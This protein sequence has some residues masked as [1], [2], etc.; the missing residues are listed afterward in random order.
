MNDSDSLIR[1][2][3]RA[4]SGEM[5]AAL[6]YRGHWL[7]VRNERE[8][9]EIRQI[10]KE[11]WVHRERL[12][13][14]VSRL[15]ARPIWWLE[16]RMALLGTIILIGCN[17]VGWFIPMY[18]AGRLESQNDREYEEAA[19]HAEALGLHALYAELKTMAEL[20]RDHEA[21]F[22]GKVAGHP[23]LPFWK[24]WFGWGPETTEPRKPH[25]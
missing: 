10:E 14:W 21:Y 2:L 12:G 7:S 22:L 15:G 13:Y 9:A 23:A 19:V 1:I 6:A 11:E 4:Y 16:L 24:K 20:E 8:I 17:M 5:T 3:R 18:F 25:E